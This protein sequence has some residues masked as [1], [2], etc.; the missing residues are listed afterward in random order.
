MVRKIPVLFWLR[1]MSSHQ[2][3]HI[4]IAV[5]LQTEVTLDWQPLLCPNTQTLRNMGR[6]SP[7][8]SFPHPF[9][10]APSLSSSQLVPHWLSSIPLQPH[11]HTAGSPSLRRGWR[12]FPRTCSF[13]PEPGWVPGE[14]FAVVR[15]RQPAPPHLSL[16]PL[17]FI[18]QTSSFSSQS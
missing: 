14:S 15:L 8:C 3:I 7:T 12:S 16:C 4:Q 11:P 1:M 13:L 5:S 10:L 2:G 18:H 9:L 6:S 17:C